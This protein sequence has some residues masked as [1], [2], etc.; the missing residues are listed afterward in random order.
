MDNDGCD[1][2]VKYK[3]SMDNHC[4][5]INIF[6]WNNDCWGHL[7]FVASVQK[8]LIRNCKVMVSDY[9]GDGLLDIALGYEYIDNWYAPEIGSEDWFNI[10]QWSYLEIFT[11]TGVKPKS[12]LTGGGK[13]TFERT[14]I[15]KFD[16]LMDFH[17]VADFNGDG[18]PDILYGIIDG[19]IEEGKS[20][21]IYCYENKQGILY[22]RGGLEFE[23]KKLETSYSLYYPYTNREDNKNDVKVGDFN[24]DG[25]ADL[26]FLCANYKMEKDLSRISSYDGVWGE[27]KDATIAF[28]TSTGESFKLESK[29]TISEERNCFLKSSIQIH[30][31]NNNGIS[32]AVHFMGYDLLTLKESGRSGYFTEFRKEKRKPYLRAIE[33]RTLNSMVDY[34]S[35]SY[36]SLL[37][38]EI[39]STPVVYNMPASL[40]KGN[41]IVVSKLSYIG[42]RTLSYS[43]ESLYYEKTGRGLIGFLKET[44]NDETSKMITKKEWNYTRPSFQ[45]LHYSER[46]FDDDGKEISSV[47]K[48]NRVEI[49]RDPKRFRVSPAGLKEI[50]YLNNTRT[51]TSYKDMNVAFMPQTIIT[52]K[53]GEGGPTKTEKIVYD[54]VNGGSGLLKKKVST[55]WSDREDSSFVN[56]KY[57]ASFLYDEKD[58]LVETV[59]KPT[60]MDE[61]KVTM[62]Y[63]S[64]GNVVKLDS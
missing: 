14:K 7:S 41:K 23:D 45:I 46:T 47:N 58:R 3:K 42:R 27:W 21:F 12:A 28:Y 26:L 51:S 34:F 40:Y 44:V 19:K 57:E 36:E 50:N 49:V 52:T 38:N 54:D 5:N 32:E 13:M 64:F 1:E 22:N 10:K 20:K 31:L 16:N 63:D 15:I 39:Y 62:K 37:R 17:A 6:D 59:S 60:G 30:D 18:L 2:F 55:Y 29:K 43:Y 48:S 24:G 11:N 9:N 53:G 35:L 33:Q 4:A 61:M 8:N 25:K 56:L